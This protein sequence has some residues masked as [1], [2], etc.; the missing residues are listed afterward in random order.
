[1]REFRQIKRFLKRPDFDGFTRKD[2]FIKGIIG[3]EWGQDIAAL[4]NMAEALHSLSETGQHSDEELPDLIEKIAQRA[5]HPKVNPYKKEI[6]KVESLGGFGYYLE[7]LNIVLGYYRLLSDDKYEALNTRITEHLVK[8]TNDS[9]NYHAKLI[10]WIRMKWAADQAAIIY[11]VWLYDQ[12]YGTRYHEELAQNWVGIL[13]RKFTDPD[14]GLFQTEVERVKRYS[15]QPRG[16]SLSYLVYYMSFFNRD[17]ALNQW[18]LYKKY[19]HFS[20]GPIKGFRE[21]LK[22]YKGGWNPDS[23]PILFGMGIAAT[24]LALKTAAAIGDGKTY[25]ELYRLMNPVAYITSLGRPIPILNRITNLGSD[26]LA[27][28][29]ILC[30]KATHESNSQRLKK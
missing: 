8:L 2:L 1:M 23:G 3:S 7:H 5:I 17:E 6:E 9:K 26:L 21:Y 15:R 13:K 28:S 24:G 18:K 30:A 19:M 10:P 20:C 29:I 22:G 14:T 12:N 11:S 4:S 16:C 25:E 27:S